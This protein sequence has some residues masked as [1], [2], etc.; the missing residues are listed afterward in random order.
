MENRYIDGLRAYNDT[1]TDSSRARAVA[2][3]SFGILEGK[4]IIWI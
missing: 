3:V 4:G 2:K 1:A